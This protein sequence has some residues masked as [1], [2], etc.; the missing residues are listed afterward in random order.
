[1]SKTNYETINCDF[2]ISDPK[3]QARNGS[4]YSALADNGDVFYG[5]SLKIEDNGLVYDLK[6]QIIE[7]QGS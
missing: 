2:V 5:K 4:H 1:M 7:T 3:S 6:Y